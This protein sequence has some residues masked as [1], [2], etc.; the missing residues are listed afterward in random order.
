M[1]PIARKFVYIAL[2]LPPEYFFLLDLRHTLPQT[3]NIISAPFQISFKLLYFIFPNPRFP[4]I[5]NIYIEPILIYIPLTYIL[6][7]ALIN[8]VRFTILIVVS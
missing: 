6:L 1:S 7:Y 3:L 8:R 4:I 5:V 2:D